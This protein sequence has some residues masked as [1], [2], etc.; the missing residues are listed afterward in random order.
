MPASVRGNWSHEPSGKGELSGLLAAEEGRRLAFS[1][2]VNGGSGSPDDVDL[3]M[4]QFVAELAVAH[5][6]EP[7]IS[8]QGANGD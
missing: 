2:I 6:G 4:D 1:L 7:E 8:A 5:W 3:A